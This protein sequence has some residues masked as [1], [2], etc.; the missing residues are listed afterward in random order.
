[1]DEHAKSFYC[2]ALTGQDLQEIQ[3]LEAKGEEKGIRYKIDPGTNSGIICRKGGR[4]TGF[5]TADCFGGP[6]VESAAIA[7]SVEDWNSMLEVL[8]LYARKNMARELLFISSPKDPL[9][10]DIL[11]SRGLTAAFSE[12]RM[13][14]DENAFIPVPIS[15]IGLRKADAGDTGFII[16]LDE[17][18]FGHSTGHLTTLDIANTRII[19]REGKPVGKL[20]VDTTDGICGIYGVVVE[21][22]SRGRGIGAQALTIMLKGLLRAGVASIYLEV[23]SENPAAYHLYE[24]LGFR[25]KSEFRYYPERLSS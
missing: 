16:S 7:D 25:V 4:M 6:A 14:L 1:M 13:V 17:E 18:A 9:V 22:N 12:F 5:M 21:A 8:S 24:K 15:E 23:D 2:T 11:T 3:F 20:R 10:T 19:L